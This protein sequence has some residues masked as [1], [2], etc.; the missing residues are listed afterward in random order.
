V[1]IALDQLRIQWTAPVVAPVE[2]AVLGTA[3]APSSAFEPPAYIVGPIAGT[4]YVWDAGN[5]DLPGAAH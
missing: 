5:D 4:D 1:L 2:T 3:G